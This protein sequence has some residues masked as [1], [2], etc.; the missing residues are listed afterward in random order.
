MLADVDDLPDG[1]IEQ[2]I[3][4]AGGQIEVGHGDA[5]FEHR[6][7][8]RIV[9]RKGLSALHELHGNPPRKRMGVIQIERVIQAA[10]T[11]HRVLGIIS[12][13]R[14]PDLIVLPDVTP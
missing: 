11:T 4:R 12:G 7:A 13:I 8:E 1:T 14:Y 10:Q 9:L 5:W 2:L 6:V 3:L